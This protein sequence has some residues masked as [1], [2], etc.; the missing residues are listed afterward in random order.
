MLQSNVCVQKVF[1]K[2]DEQNSDQEISE[3]S[4]SAECTVELKE[5]E[6]SA[7]EADLESANSKVE[8]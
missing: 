3:W 2:E 4:A 5:E 8:P 7:P 1:C 6:F